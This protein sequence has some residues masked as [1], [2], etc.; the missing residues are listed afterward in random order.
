MSKTSSLL[1]A[2]LLTA[3]ACSGGG[4]PTP[5]PAIRVTLTPNAASVH[6]NRSVQLTATVHNSTNTGVMWSLSGTG[7]NGASCGMIS[8]AGLYTAPVSVPSTATVTVKA[9]SVADISKSASATITILAAVVVTIS[10]SSPTIAIDS[11]QQFT[12][13][14]E[15][16]IDS[17][18]TWGV[19][20]SEC[21]GPECGTISTTGFY[22][23]PSV[24]PAAPAISITV[25]SVEDTAI[26]DSATAM[27]VDEDPTAYKYY[28]LRVIEDGVLVF[29]INAEHR[30]ADSPSRLA[31]SGGRS[32]VFGGPSFRQVRLCGEYKHIALRFRLRDLCCHW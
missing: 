16:A 10:P 7:C 5:P 23:A 28:A 18:V 17:G 24:V 31:H 19:S 3:Y 25:T 21:T 1:V 13:T 11:T 4:E 26:A 14:V 15:N 6:V 27:I 12:A 30:S 20:G 22:T 2:I 9:T 29:S 8:G 32:R